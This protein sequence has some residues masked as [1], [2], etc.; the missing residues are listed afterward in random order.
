[1]KKKLG[2]LIVSYNGAFWLKK[3]LTT[4]KQHYLDTSTY[5]VDVL[6]VDNN[7]TDDTRAMLT[8]E[9]NWV[10]SIFLDQNNGFSY[11]NNRGIE[12]MN[13]EYIMLLNP[14]TECTEESNF[15]KL[16]KYL[17]AHKKIGVL[18]PK[19]TF[20][21]GELEPAC[22][23][24]EP[25][26]WN[27]LCYMTGLSRLFPRWPLFAG[28]HQ[29]YKDLDTIHEIDACTGAA[30]IVRQSVI[31]RV[32]MLD[33]QFFMYAEDLD[34]CKRIR[35]A[36]YAIVYN[37]DATIIHHKYKSGIKSSSQKIAKKTK[38]YLYETMLQYYDK[39]YAE[40]YPRFVRSL[41]HLLIVIKKGGV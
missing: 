39:H 30:M 41:L 11:A 19:I 8:E 15:D 10:E 7:S 14:D 27:S 3:T 18:T 34:W 40:Q 33:E 35:E 36:G 17:D 6:V 23:R 9:F 28:Y 25:T 29:S 38:K 37:P 5:A 32:G 21:D 31:E 20:L 12:R 2:I 26:P 24:G 4:L 13:H 1:M 16:I 22:H